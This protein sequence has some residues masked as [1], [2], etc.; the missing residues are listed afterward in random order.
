MKTIFIYTVINIL[1]FL[2]GCSSGSSSD[3]PYITAIIG[4]SNCASYGTI[5][6]YPD[7]LGW[8]SYC[9]PGQRVNKVD[10][11]PEA[12]RI[13]MAIGI[14]DVTIGKIKGDSSHDQ[15]VE[16][17]RS[18]LNQAYD[19]GSDLV[20]IIPPPTTVDRF[21]EDIKQLSISLRAICQNY[22]ATV[23]ETVEVYEADGLHLSQEGHDAMVANLQKGD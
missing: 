10:Y 14:N 16:A 5:T 12:D 21:K 4:D 2:T 15:A 9:F 6:A 7:Q 17:Y 19:M 1:L 3:T 8:D 11:M 20:C 23:Y 18:L 13:V 22:G